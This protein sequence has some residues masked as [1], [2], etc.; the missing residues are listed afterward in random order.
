[1]VGR[2]VDGCL[3]SGCK[4]TMLSTLLKM[5]RS[6]QQINAKS[7][8]KNNCFLVFR[9]LTAGAEIKAIVPYLTS[10][11]FGGLTGLL[12]HLP[13]L[14]EGSSS[15]PLKEQKFPV[16]QSEEEPAVKP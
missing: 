5:P 13:Q 1:M 8:I 10:D 15:A 2:L 14:N 6:R 11:S 4:A 7:A 16:N 12:Q 3:V 9:F